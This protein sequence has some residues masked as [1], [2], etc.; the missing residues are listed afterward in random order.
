MSQRIRCK[1]A[2]DSTVRLG[3]LDMNSVKNYTGGA[4]DVAQR[5]RTLTALSEV[6]EFNSQKLHGGSQPSVMGSDDALF[7]CV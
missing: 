4:R 3:D 6:P 2:N 5:L 7:W 1:E